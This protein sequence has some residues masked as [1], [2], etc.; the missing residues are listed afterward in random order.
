V[1]QPIRQ[2]PRTRDTVRFVPFIESLTVHGLD[3]T[4]NRDPGRVTHL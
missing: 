2:Q 1:H 4:R 3:L